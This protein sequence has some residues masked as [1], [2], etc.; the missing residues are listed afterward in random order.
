[1][2]KIDCNGYTEQT[3]MGHYR[4]QI[5]LVW[6]VPHEEVSGKACS[7]TVPI[8]LKLIQYFHNS[9]QWFACHFKWH[10]LSMKSHRNSGARRLKRFFLSESTRNLINHSNFIPLFAGWRFSSEN[11]LSSNQCNVHAKKINFASCY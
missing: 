2:T 3:I 8:G 11:L 6:N 1:M 7:E 5:G 10:I 9:H 4:S